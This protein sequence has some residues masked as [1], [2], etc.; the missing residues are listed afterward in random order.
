MVSCSCVTFESYLQNTHDILHY[1]LVH[2]HSSTY[3]LRKD[4]NDPYSAK[5]WASKLH[6][7]NM[8]LT[9]LVECFGV[10]ASQLKTK[11]SWFPRVQ[12]LKK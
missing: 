11:N 6:K 7:E 10:M 3:F 5:V 12:D 2:F 1:V 8:D 4:Y 9:I